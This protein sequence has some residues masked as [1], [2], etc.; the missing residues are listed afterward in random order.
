MV[1][2]STKEKSQSQWILSS[3]NSCDELEDYPDSLNETASAPGQTGTETSSG[4]NYQ[5]ANNFLWSTASGGGEN[6]K[7]YDSIDSNLASSLYQPHGEDLAECDS[8][9]KQLSD[10]SDRK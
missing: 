9:E 5:S 4:Q 1:S 3:F 2:S 8:L 10:S 6:A 7:F